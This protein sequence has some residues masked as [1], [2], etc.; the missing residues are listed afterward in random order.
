MARNQKNFQ[1]FT[2][3]DD[4]ALSWNM[5]GEDGGAA[6]GVDG[7]AALVAGQPRWERQTKRM[8]CRKVIFHDPVTFRTIDPIIYTPTA[9]AAIHKGDILAVQVTGLATTV[10]YECIAKVPEKQPR[11]AGARQLADS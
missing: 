11:D 5:R 1:L 7:H 4:N 9:Y 6:A 10:N 2:Y 8:H 3:V